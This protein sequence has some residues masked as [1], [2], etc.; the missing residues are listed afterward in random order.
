MIPVR[1]I[2]A[3][4]SSGVRLDVTWPAVWAGGVVTSLLFFASIVAHEA[5]H[6]VVAVRTGIPVR[7]IRL[8]IFGG[9][10]EMAREPDRPGRSS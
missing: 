1:L 2:D 7:S 10:A 8:F 4:L 3:S 9:L 6:T 5:A